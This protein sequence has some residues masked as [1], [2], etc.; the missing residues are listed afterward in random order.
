MLSHKYA[1]DLLKLRRH[2]RRIGHI[3]RGKNGLDTLR[4]RKRGARSIQV[5]ETLK[6]AELISNC[7]T[8]CFA[9]LI[10]ARLHMTSCSPF[11]VVSI[12]VDRLERRLDIGG[13]LPSPRHLNLR[14]RKHYLPQRPNFI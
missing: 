3:A 10:A 6:L 5:E 7:I 4:L 8:E 9:W 14:E 11:D 12:L 2:C 1:V 13:G